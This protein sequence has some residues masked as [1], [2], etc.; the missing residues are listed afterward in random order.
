MSTPVLAGDMSAFPLPEILLMLNNNK[1]TGALRCTDGD[2]SKTIEWET[3]QIVFAR[4][5]LDE[6]R[7]GSHLVA[8]GKI[9]TRQLD[10]ASQALGKDERLG[11]ALIRLGM[12]APNDLFEAVRGQVT[13]IVYSLFHWKAG[14]FEFLPDPPAGEKISL[15]TTVMNLIMEGTRRLDELSRV[16]EKIQSDQMVLAPAKTPEEVA[17]MVQLSPFEKTILGLVDGRRTVR[18]VVDRG[19]RGEFD[20]LQALYSLLSAGLI[21]VQVLSLNT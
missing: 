7:L 8:R 14:R 11:K 1:K 3:G 21:R 18:E 4:S 19:G 10:E 15:N 12:L 2:V 17:A 13:E 5:S 20:A 6:D 16:R 9:S